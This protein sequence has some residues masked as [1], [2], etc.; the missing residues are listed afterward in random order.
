[1][2]HFIWIAIVTLSG[3]NAFT[4]Y[5]FKQEYAKY[6]SLANRA[7]LVYNGA[8]TPLW[9]DSVNFC[10][11]TRETE[12]T[13][14]YKV[15]IVRKTKTKCSKEDLPGS[16]EQRERRPQGGRRDSIP[17]PDGK[18]KA[19]IFDNNLWI[20]E[21]GDKAKKEKV[22]LSFDGTANNFYTNNIIWSPDSKKIVC[23]SVKT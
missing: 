10:Y 3:S 12:G 11:E 13:I 17:S 9:V 19:F 5:D 18:W 8:I 22:K 16:R 23:C 7:R 4:Q 15:D 14:Y 21:T 6:D 20:E 2:K 1:M